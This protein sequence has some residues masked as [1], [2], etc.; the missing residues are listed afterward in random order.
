MFNHSGIE[1][2]IRV[3]LWAECC[4]TSM[5]LTNVSIDTTST[6]SSHLKYYKRKSKILLRTF[7]ELEVVKDSE[8]IKGKIENRGIL[9]I[10]LGY[11]EN[12][13]KGTY[14]FYNLKTNRVIMSRDIIWVD[15][16][17][18]DLKDMSQEIKDII[19]DYPNKENPIEEDIFT[20]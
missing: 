15:K 18:K 19:E 6:Q 17:M 13:S 2:N 8:S 16:L 10:F 9:S 1:G 5:I 4:L 11:S 7:G 3:K 14:R 20:P 12:R